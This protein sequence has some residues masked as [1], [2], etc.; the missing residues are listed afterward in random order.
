MWP[1]SQ[2]KKS[3]DASATVVFTLV[4][5]TPGTPHELPFV[6]TMA[7]QIF[8]ELRCERVDFFTI[9]AHEPLIRALETTRYARPSRFTA[10]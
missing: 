3:V 6:G 5:D 9:P 8:A 1:V 7:N 10:L 4:A 2:C